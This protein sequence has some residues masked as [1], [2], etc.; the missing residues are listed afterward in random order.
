M[1]LAALS[2]PPFSL[3]SDLA[4][5]SGS[6]LTKWESKRAADGGYIRAGRPGWQKRHPTRLVRSR[7]LS[8]GEVGTT[9]SGV[10]TPP[11]SDLVRQR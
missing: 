5:G 3:L 9:R 10:E 4:H 11:V 1:A 8:C 6:G 7:R 2:A